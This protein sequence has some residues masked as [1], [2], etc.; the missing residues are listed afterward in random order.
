M[1]TYFCQLSVNDA[2]SNIGNHSTLTLYESTFSFWDVSRKRL[3]KYLFSQ[4]SPS[5]LDLLYIASFVYLADCSSPRAQTLTNWERKIKLNIPVLN[6]DSMN[7]IKAELIAALNFLSG[8]YWEIEFRTRKLDDNEIYQISKTKQLKIP[9]Q[10]DCVSMLSGGLDSCIGAIDLLESNKKPLFVGCHGRGASVKPYQ[11]KVFSI[12][13]NNYN[14]TNNNFKQFSLERNA[15]GETGELTTRSRSFYFFMHGV[16]MANIYNISE[17]IIPENGVISLNIPLTWSRIGS[18]ST[19]TTHPYYMSLLNIILEKLGSPM[20]LVNPYQFKT[21]GEM[22]CECKNQKL[23]KELAPFTM[24]CSHP[25]DRY[26]GEDSIKDSH[27][28]YCVPCTIRRAA[29]K[30]AGISDNS[31]YRDPEREVARQNFRSFEIGI[32]SK[33]EIGVFDVLR[34]GPIPDADNYNEY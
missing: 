24:S 16:A 2:V 25:S 17:L 30:K 4:I 33:Q 28:G 6:L 11:N 26:S 27:C 19:R 7:A 14:I 10:Y 15:N 22:M 8:D 18:S 9:E 32:L 21:K 12:L 20:H 1:Y 34:A 13:K 5:I 31:V 3:N 29:F 23:L